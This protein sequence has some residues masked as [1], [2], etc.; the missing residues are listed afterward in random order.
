MECAVPVLQTTGYQLA[1]CGL[2]DLTLFLAESHNGWT[3]PGLES[4]HSLPVS[5]SDPR[6]I[7]NLQSFDVQVLSMAAIVITLG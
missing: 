6:R 1:S 5:Y 7:F 4:A 3:A 2:F